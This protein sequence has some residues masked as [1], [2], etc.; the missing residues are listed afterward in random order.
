VYI[1]LLA[2]PVYGESVNIGRVRGD[3]SLT[4]NEWKAGDAQLLLA[5]ETE[6]RS[7]TSSS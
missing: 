7:D 1:K 4:G 2:V 6:N 3:D 5:H